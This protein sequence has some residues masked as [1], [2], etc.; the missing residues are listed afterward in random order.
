M[1]KRYYAIALTIVRT[2][3]FTQW[4]SFDYRQEI[5]LDDEN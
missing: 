1:Y 2:T 5:N 4:K 3:V